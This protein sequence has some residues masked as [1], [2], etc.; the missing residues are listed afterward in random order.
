[1]KKNSVQKWCVIAIVMLV[2]L[3]IVSC[4]PDP[5]A[6][7]VIEF[8][9]GT[10]AECVAIDLLNPQAVICTHPDGA[11]DIYSVQFIENVFINGAQVWTR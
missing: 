8:T 4:S 5:N 6:K 10:S 9:D 11:V 1:M 7:V 3:A 2:V